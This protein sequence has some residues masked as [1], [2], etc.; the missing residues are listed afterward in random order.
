MIS[1]WVGLLIFDIKRSFY[2]N[3]RLSGTPA[4]KSKNIILQLVD[5]H[6]ELSKSGVVQLFFTPHPPR[7]VNISPWSGRLPPK[8]HFVTKH[9]KRDE[10]DEVSVEEDSNS[11]NKPLVVSRLLSRS[12]TS[13]ND[14]KL[15]Q[16]QLQSPKSVKVPTFLSHIQPGSNQAVLDPEKKTSFQS[17]ISGSKSLKLNGKLG[18]W[19][20]ILK[21]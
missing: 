6:Q 21:I 18:Q 10:E 14:D 15:D 12:R 16:P 4:V 2:E 3:F 20:S 19:G 7:Q 9:R 11:P 8:I 5:N 17:Y 13:L 1:T